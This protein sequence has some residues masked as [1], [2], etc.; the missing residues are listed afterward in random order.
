LSY[1]RSGPEAW[2]SLQDLRCPSESSRSQYRVALD[3]RPGEG[4][5]QDLGGGTPPRRRRDG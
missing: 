4:Q 5:T 1:G 3:L 2:A